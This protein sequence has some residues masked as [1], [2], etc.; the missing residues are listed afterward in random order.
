MSDAPIEPQDY[1]YGVKVVQIEDL[2]IARGLTRRPKSS[3]RHRQTAYDP[4]ERR[5]WCSDCETEVDPFD[6]FVMIVEF[7]DVAVKKLERREAALQEVEAFRVRSR[8][9]KTMDKYWRSIN[10]APC[11]PH[12]RAGILPE[13]VADKRLLTVDKK[14]ELERRRFAEKSKNS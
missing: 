11:C 8:A 6:A 12:C 3:C 9:A 7:F 13:D 4:H 1:L 5:I 2:R 14:R 10:S